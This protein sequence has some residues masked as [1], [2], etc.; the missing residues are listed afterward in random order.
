MNDRLMYFACGATAVVSLALGIGIGY[1]IWGQHGIPDAPAAEHRQADDSLELKR[2]PVPVA[3]VGTPAHQLPR[4]TEI[5]RVA[6]TVQPKAKDCPQQRLDLSL[7][8]DAGGTRVIASSP[9]GRVVEGTDQ[10]I[11]GALALDQ[12]RPWAAGISF[13]GRQGFGVLVQRDFWRTRL[14]VEVNALRDGGA[15]ARAVVSWTW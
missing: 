10:P 1:L 3:N 15:E 11:V 7:V 14:G 6:V 12:S 9:D 13:A 5:R 2:Q 4:G 8:S